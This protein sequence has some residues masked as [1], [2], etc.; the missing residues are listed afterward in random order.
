MIEVEIEDPAWTA[1]LPEAA[2]LA[3]RAARIAAG[4][5][6]SEIAILLTSDD[7]LRSLNGRF[8]GKDKPTNVLAFPADQLDRL[9]DIALAF[10]VCRAEAAEQGKPLANHLRH[11]IVHGVLHLMGY[12]HT[13]EADAARMEALEHDLLADMNIPDPYA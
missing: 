7:A 5:S 6:K 9:G 8:L 13:G 4:D 2:E 10:G 11:L 1:A 3:R 12:D